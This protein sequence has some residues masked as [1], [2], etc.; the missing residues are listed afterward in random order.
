MRLCLMIILTSMLAIANVALVLGASW[1][2]IWSEITFNLS[3]S[4][5]NKLS[6]NGDLAQSLGIKL[7]GGNAYL[8]DGFADYTAPVLKSELK[9]LSKTKDTIIFNAT[10]QGD[11][12][13]IS[14]KF[15][16]KLVNGKWLVDDFTGFI[17]E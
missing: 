15:S 16:I 9:V 10:V 11:S 5:V 4:Y 1:L 6:I 7:I 14:R 8:I 13:D 17:E 3:D 12:K 2:K